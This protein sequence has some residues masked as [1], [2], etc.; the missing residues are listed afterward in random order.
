MLAFVVIFSGYTPGETIPPVCPHGSFCP[1]EGSGCEALLANGQTCQ[2][3]RDE[4]C[5][6]PPDWT[7]LASALNYNGSVCLQEK[8]RFVDHQPIS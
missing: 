7:D 2:L 1:D 3:N 4:Q 5:A 6:P 8:C